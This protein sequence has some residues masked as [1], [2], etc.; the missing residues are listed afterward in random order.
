MPRS[1]IGLLLVLGWVAAEI[2]TY[3]AVIRNAGV[4]VAVIIG[5]GSFAL[6]VLILKRLGLRLG[7]LMEESLRRDREDPLAF[8]RA[9]SMAAIA[10]LLLILPGFLTNL[11]G[12]VLLLLFPR[13]WLGPTGNPARKTH[14][15]EEDIVDL[16]ES[17]WSSA[18]PQ[19]KALRKR[20]EIDM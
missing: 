16:D 9:V 19:R 17:E 1:S 11:V 12:I 7:P 15:A 8:L 5:V 18:D 3:A 14:G 6:G 10:A 20:D 4:L 2:V 13:T